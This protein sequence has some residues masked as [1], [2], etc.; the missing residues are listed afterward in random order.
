MRIP[1]SVRSK[2]YADCLKT[3]YNGSS[4][5][6]KRTSHDY[7]SELLEKYRDNYRQARHKHATQILKKY[8]DN[9]EKLRRTNAIS[10]EK[11]VH[12]IKTVDTAKPLE[13]GRNKLINPH[14]LLTGKKQRKLLME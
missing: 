3:T 7:A 4:D 2:T 14:M 6:I 12:N 11:S 8:R 13:S 9:Y 10:S 5:I 1:N